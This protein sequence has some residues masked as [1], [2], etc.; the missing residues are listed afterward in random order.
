MLR[1]ALAQW[2]ECVEEHVVG[3]ASSAARCDGY[4]AASVSCAACA[5]AAS[6]DVP[7]AALTPV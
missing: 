7:F 4:N 6:I 1:V 5:I 2:L 3:R